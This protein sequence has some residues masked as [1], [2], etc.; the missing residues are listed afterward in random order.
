MNRTMTTVAIVA[1]LALAGC[2]G[3]AGDVEDAV[4]EYTTAYS[5]G[6]TETAYALLSARCQKEI[7]EEKY[8]TLVEAA[9]K[10]YGELTVEDVEV[11]EIDDNTATVS[12]DVGVPALKQAG[13]KFVREGGSWH[14]DGC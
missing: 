4:S 11:E 8:S 5:S 7:G 14:W 3:D 1:V 9:N 6:D 12:Y 10:M 13:Q 2:S